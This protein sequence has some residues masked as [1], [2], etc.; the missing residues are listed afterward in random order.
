MMALSEREQKRFEQVI[1]L[2]QTGES[3]MDRIRRA[4]VL[5]VGLGPVGAAAAQWLSACGVGML[6]LADHGLLHENALPLQPQLQIQD[7]GKYKAKSL[8]SRLWA[9][10][11]M[12]KHYPLLL[13]VNPEN[14]L[15][16][17]NSFEIV[18]D[19]TDDEAVHLL[20]NDACVLQSKPLLMAGIAGTSFWMGQ[21]VLSLQQASY[22]CAVYDLPK[23][24]S[25]LPGRWSFAAGSAG[26][27][28]AQQ[29]IHLILAAD[30][31][32]SS[33]LYLQDVWTG[34]DETFAL[35][36]DEKNVAKVKAEGILSAEAYGM[37]ILPPVED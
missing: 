14:V 11:P 20:L 1:A 26:I 30:H 7:V 8:C 19:C 9:M 2:E 31:A 22:R 4:G 24:R 36:R 17:V 37:T 28:L 35:Q 18:L 29:A 21:F 34:E 32:Q 27:R 3:G 23:M 12:S 13:Q 33:H 5:I 15:S 10:N 16:L 6:G 25:S